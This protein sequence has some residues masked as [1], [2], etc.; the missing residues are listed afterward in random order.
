MVGA[1]EEAIADIITEVRKGRRRKYRRAL[2][3]QTHPP[4]PRMLESRVQTTVAA[5]VLAEAGD[6]IPMRDRSR[7]VS[8]LIDPR[9]VF[10]NAEVTRP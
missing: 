6:F 2:H 5:G 7:T 3:P 1:L 10:A 9:S 4:V 8:L